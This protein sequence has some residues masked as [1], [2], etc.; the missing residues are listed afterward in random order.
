MRSWNIKANL[1]EK[2]SHLDKLTT[3]IREGYILALVEDRATV[4]Y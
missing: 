4:F 3:T 2:V 1:I